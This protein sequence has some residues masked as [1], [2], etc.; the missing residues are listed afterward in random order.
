MND[1]RPRWEIEEIVEMVRLNLYNHGHKYG[2]PAIRE[3]IESMEVN[4]LP[5]ISTISRM[6]KERELTNW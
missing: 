4:P 2:A 5:S 3:E 1:K 6:L